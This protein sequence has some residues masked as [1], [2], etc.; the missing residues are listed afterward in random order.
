MELEIRHLRLMVA[1]AESGGVTRAAGILHLTQSALSH[2]LREMERRLGVRLFLR[3]KRRMVPTPAG[4][5][6][7]G[8]AARLLHEMTRAEEDVRLIGREGRGVIRVATQCYTCY[9]WI[10]RAL[11]EFARS[12]PGVDVQIVPEATYRS[13][14]ALLDGELDVAVA[15][16]RLAIAQKRRL[17]AYPL[18]EDEILGVVSTTHAL[19]RRTRLLPADFADQD[20]LLHVPFAESQVA[21]EFLAAKGVRPRRV[22]QIRLTEGIVEMARAGLG[23]GVLARWAVARELREK[24]LRGL[25]LGERGFRR[26]FMAYT[27][28]GAEARPFLSD[29]VNLLARISF[30]PEDSQ[31]AREAVLC[32]ARP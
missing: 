17:A 32:E 1:V 25:P 6:L 3:M 13:I 15:S 20:L 9:G 29:F 30:A 7:L 19:S 18:F 26:R 10:P 8:S 5:R 31:P 12:W 22:S 23:I 21:Q 28:R 11:P 16:E 14:E 2:Q 24:R 4:E 27:N